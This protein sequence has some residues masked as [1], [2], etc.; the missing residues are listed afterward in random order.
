M[1]AFRLR[2]RSS[3]PHKLY[4]AA[5]VIVGAVIA[6]NAVASGRARGKPADDQAALRRVATLVARGATQS[7]VFAAVAEELARLFGAEATFVAPLNRDPREVLRGALDAGRPIRVGAEDLAVGPWSATVARLRLRSGIVAP[8]MVDSR[9][10]GVTFVGSSNGFPPGAESRI[11]DFTELSALAI[12]NTHASDQLARL[13]EVQAALRR[14]AVLIA[15]GEPPERVF[16]AVTDEVLRHFGD[17]GTVRLVRYELDDSTTLLAH[18]GTPKPYAEAGQQY[19]SIRPPQGVSETVRRTGRPARVDDYRKL[20]LDPRFA[21]EGVVAA[22]AIPVFVNG[23][24]WGHIAI[25]SSRGPLPAGLESRMSEF[26][27]LI[28][29]AV[30]GAQIRDELTVSR[31][32][33]VAAADE[34][35]RRIERDLHDGAQQSLVTLALRLRSAATEA[36]ARDEAHDELSDAVTECMTVIDQ[37]RELSHGIHPAVL[38]ESGLRAALRALRRRSP[39]PLKVDVRIEGRLP[40]PVEIGAYYVVTEILTNAAK[41]ARASGVDVEAEAADGML[42]LRVHDDGIGGA[43]PKRGSGLLGLKD[44]IEAL[45]GSFDVHSPPGG[46]TTVTCMVPIRTS[47]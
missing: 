12:S 34:A 25:G 4:V 24:L 26:T 30:A 9:V 39:L 29:T 23:R 7:A 13:G 43:D 6:R 19:G 28:A 42:T 2:S 3:V 33:I 36:A 10:W 11:A 41:H 5:A 45:G 8:I 46:G 27:E 32:R 16:A 35:R 40:M 17:G 21:R 15:K 18:A 31:A 38:S 44:R 47:P 1:T 20:D 37:L 22:V 14:I